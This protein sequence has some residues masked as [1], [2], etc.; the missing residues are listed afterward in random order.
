MG[1]VLAASGQEGLDRPGERRFDLVFLDLAMLRMP[2][3]ETFRLIRQMECDVGVMI[4]T[5]YPNSEQMARALQMGP[6]ALMK[7][8][9]P[10]AD[11]TLVLETQTKAG[12]PEALRSR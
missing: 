7:K 9:F 4:I 2:D 12:A 3:S 11:L 6:F 1:C 10:L 5:F 8:P